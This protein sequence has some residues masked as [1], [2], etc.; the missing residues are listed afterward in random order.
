MNKI[1]L[2]IKRE[3][4]TRVKKRS[5]ITHLA[6]PHGTSKGNCQNKCKASSFAIGGEPDSRTPQ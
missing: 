1:G 2:I 5:F 6:P 3:Y 4:L